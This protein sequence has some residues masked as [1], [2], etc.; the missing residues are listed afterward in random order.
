MHIW[1]DS[2]GHLVLNLQKSIIIAR[3]ILEMRFLI[4]VTFFAWINKGLI[5]KYWPIKS[6]NTD[7]H[8]GTSEMMIQVLF[9]DLIFVACKSSEPVNRLF[10][11]RQNQNTNQISEASELAADSS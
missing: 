9:T 4:S 8:P 11:E 6:D 3:S 5:N 2:D 1:F 7:I 10:Q